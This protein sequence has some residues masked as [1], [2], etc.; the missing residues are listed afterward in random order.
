[1]HPYMLEGMIEDKRRK[2]S[3]MPNRDMILSYVAKLEN[4]NDDDDNV[5][6]G[7]FDE[8]YMMYGGDKYLAV[9]FLILYIII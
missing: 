6:I 9:I 2:S 7:N 5:S 4:K 1:M 8:N 3:C